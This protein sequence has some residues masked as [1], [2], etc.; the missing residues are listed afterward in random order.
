MVVDILLEETGPQLS[1]RGLLISS[2]PPGVPAFYYHGDLVHD[3]DVLRGVL[4]DA[5]VPRIPLAA[6]LCAYLEQ[7]NLF[8]YDPMH[9]RIICVAIRVAAA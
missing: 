7:S 2:P 9:D 6:S 3:Y 5:G 1:Y 8:A 4:W